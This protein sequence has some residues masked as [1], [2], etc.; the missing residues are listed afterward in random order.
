MYRLATGTA[1][2]ISGTWKQSPAKGQSHELHAT[3]VQ[4]T[5]DVDPKVKAPSL[6]VPY[7]IGSW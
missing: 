3:Q 2:Q 6:L 5:G 4:V 7:S 1:V